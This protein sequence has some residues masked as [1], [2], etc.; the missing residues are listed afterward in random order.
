[1]YLSLK[2]CD[3]FTTKVKCLGFMVSTNG[4]AMD[5]C[6]VAAIQEWPKPKSYHE[7][8]VFLGF[9]NFYWRF[10]HHYSHIAGSLTGLLKGSQKGVKSGPFE[11]PEAADQ[12]FQRL[13]NAFSQAP[14]L[15][16]FDPQLLV[17]IKTDALEYAV[18]GILTQLQEDN[19]QWHPVAFHSQKMILAEWNYETH[20][21]KLL[22]IVTVFKH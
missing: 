16:H 10:I 3:F 9:V 18:A 2:K 11:W 21:Q 22:A 20:D 17:Q 8:Q 13:T 7:V 5:Q 14:L 12:A 1:M 6:W 19:K 15:K 4:V